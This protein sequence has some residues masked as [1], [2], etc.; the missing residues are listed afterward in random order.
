M[1]LRAI[2]RQARL[3]RSKRLLYLVAFFVSD[4]ALD[5]TAHDVAYQHA[6][7]GVAQLLTHLL[8]ADGHLVVFC[9]VTVSLQQILLLVAQLLRV[10]SMT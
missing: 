3:E 10:T 4:A 9:F 2:A 7:A 1:R 5:G 8:H 6:D